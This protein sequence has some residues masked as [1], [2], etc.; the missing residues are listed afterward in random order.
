MAPAR[1]Q[2]ELGLDVGYEIV[3]LYRAVEDAHARNAEGDLLAF[4]IEEGG[5]DGREAAARPL[6][7][8]LPG[9]TL[10]SACHVLLPLAYSCSGTGH[11]TV[12]PMRHLK[13]PKCNR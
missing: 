7:L 6:D 9:R 5:V 12:R 11:V 8:K 13:T 4:E 1:D 10:A 2:V 3:K